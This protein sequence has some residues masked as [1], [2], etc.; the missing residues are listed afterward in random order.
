MY[1]NPSYD[2]ISWAINWGIA[3]NLPNETYAATLRRRAEAAM[4]RSVTQRRFRRDLYHQM[5]I[6]MDK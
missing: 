2:W 6:A 3:Y 5:E 1:G 4:P